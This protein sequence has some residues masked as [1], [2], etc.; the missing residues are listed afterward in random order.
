[1]QTV[2]TQIR[3]RY[4]QGN[5]TWGNS[6]QLGGKYFKDKITSATSEDSNLACAFAQ[7]Y[8]SSL[9]AWAFRAYGLFKIV[10]QVYTF[11]RIN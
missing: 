4:E 2:K 3:R 5:E 6:E 11:T 7:S 10:L 8:R 1:M 9:F